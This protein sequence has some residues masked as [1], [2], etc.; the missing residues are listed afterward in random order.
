M[1]VLV[2]GGA[3]YIGSH[4]AWRLLDAGERVVILDSLQGGHEW[5]VPPAALFHRGDVADGQALAHALDLAGEPVD[6]V[7]HFAGSVSVPESVEHPERYYRN[8]TCATLALVEGCRAA[9]ISNF[10]FSST[11]AVYGEVGGRPV[12]EK[13]P[14]QPASPYGMSKLMSERMLSD[15]AGAHGLRCGVLRYFNVAGA[16]PQGRTGHSTRGAGHLLKVACEAALGLRDGLTIHG[17]DYPTRDG[18]AERDFIHIADLVEAHYLAL[19]KLRAGDAGFT[20][21]CG[22]GRGYT[23]LET[24]SAV[25]RASGKDFAVRT[26][27][28]RPGDIASVIADNRQILARLGWTPAHDDIDMIAGHALAWERKLLQRSES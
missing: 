22:Y 3:G 17:I 27:P 4:M 28:R 12:N 15:I 11:A 24:I 9:G 18:T 6:A 21:N 10:I 19:Q 5:S 7:L 26:G 13:A 2:T 20:L 14:T 1:A 23:V 25:K 16:D 8:N